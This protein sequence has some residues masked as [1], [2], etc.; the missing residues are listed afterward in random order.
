MEPAYTE[1]SA[2]ARPLAEALV[3]H[4]GKEFA[5]FGHSMGALISF[6]VMRELRKVYGKE[7]AHLFVSGCYAPQIPDPN[8]LY[9]LPD[10]EFLA[11]INR[12][13]G[14]PAAEL[15]ST[16]LMQLMLPTLRADCLVTESY[17][18]QEDLPFECP[19]TVFGGT[20]D[21]IAKPEDLEKWRKHTNAAFSQH[22][23]AGKH[24]FIETALTSILQ[25]ISREINKTLAVSAYR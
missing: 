4:L 21:T 18:F 13:E 17:I 12:L 7:A 22:A 15:Q 20:E 16:E 25:I 2:I 3:P 19:I 10:H 24:F 5:F 1:L 11:E 8:P 6:E 9:K 23:F 14:T